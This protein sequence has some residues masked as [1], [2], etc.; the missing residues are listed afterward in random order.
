MTT[1]GRLGATVLTT[2]VLAVPVLAASAS[3]A[4]PVAAGK[5]WSTIARWEGAQQQACKV[6]VRGGAAWK[7]YGRLV[8]GQQARIGAGMNVRHGDEVTS[9]WRSPLIDE[10][11]TS[12]VGSVVLPR[13]PGRV[14]E[15]FQFQSQSGTGGV[16]RLA[17]IG[18]C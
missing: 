10:G 6:S 7:I 13:K 15:A 9:T 1:L 14:L 3:A 12:Q 16:I 2:A 5:H 11:D 8:N 18:S 4:A 17:R